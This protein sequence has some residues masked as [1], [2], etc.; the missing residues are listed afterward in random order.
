MDSSSRALEQYTKRCEIW[1][2][3]VEI[4]RQS[5]QRQFSKNSLRLIH[6]QRIELVQNSVCSC[7]V[8]RRRNKRIVLLWS[9]LSNEHC[10]AAAASMLNKRQRIKERI[11][12]RIKTH[13]YKNIII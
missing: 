8:A 4:R 9:C 12:L 5:Y 7:V 13:I 6:C 3:S 11:K 2:S 1:T 10:Y